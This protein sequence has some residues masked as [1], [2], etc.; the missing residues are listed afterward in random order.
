MPDNLYFQ[1]EK[2]VTFGEKN[3]ITNP[4]RVKLIINY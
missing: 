1:S 3:K 2:L 4:A